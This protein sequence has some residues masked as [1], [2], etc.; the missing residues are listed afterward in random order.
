MGLLTWIVGPETL[1]KGFRNLKQQRSQLSQ[2]VHEEAMRAIR[3]RFGE[4]AEAW[5]KKHPKTVRRIEQRLFDYSLGVLDQ[6]EDMLR[7]LTLL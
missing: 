4:G 5:I 7:D 2:I 3:R 1:E 6:S